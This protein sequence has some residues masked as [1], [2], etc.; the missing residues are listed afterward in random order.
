[1]RFIHFGCWNE[2]GYKINKTKSALTYT[3]DKLKK[4]TK[5]NKTDFI[6]IAGDNY[7]KSIKDSSNAGDEE[8]YKYFKSGF[9]GLPKSI[10]KYLIFGNHDIN[11]QIKLTKPLKDKLYPNLADIT[12][13]NCKILNLQQ[14]YGDNSKQ[15]YTVFNDILFHEYNS[16]LIIMLDSN[17]LNKF[18]KDKQ[19]IG[20]YKYLFDSFEKTNSTT[21]N[22]LILHQIN[23]IIKL[24]ESKKHIQNFIF[25][26]H[27]PIL[28][29][30]N[31]SENKFIV[32]KNEGLV[33][34]FTNQQLHSLINNKN[35]FYLCAD[36]HLYQYGLVTVNS[37]NIKQYIVG[38][39]GAHLDNYKA[40]EKEFKNIYGNQGL[41]YKVLENYNNIYG[42]LVIDINTIDSNDIISFKFNPSININKISRST[43]EVKNTTEN[44]YLNILQGGCKSI[45]EGLQPSASGNFSSTN[46]EY[47]DIKK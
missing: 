8:N 47:I 9:D 43:K 29:C 14:Q 1:M 4:Y 12:T 23:S 32:V 10:K 19:N 15:K 11:D 35:I 17:I 39:G 41:N 28:A 7:Y 25:V 37:L 13:T 16:T 40:N 45:P 30:K 46:I 31:T 3:L 24:I 42:F 20:C 26:G 5:S 6:I 18:N 21:M 36:V 38:T 2:S 22:E 27:H 33:N 34:L 44:T